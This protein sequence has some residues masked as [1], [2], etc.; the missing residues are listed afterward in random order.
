MSGAAVKYYLEVEPDVRIAVTLDD[1]TDPWTTPETVLMLHGN[2]ESAAAWFAWVPLFARRYRI[3]RP[4]MRGFGNSTPMREDYRW[5][6]ARLV[7]D[8]VAVC[9]RQ[10]AACVHVVAAKIS[11]QIALKFAIDHPDM[12]RSLTLVG[13]PP[14]VRELATRVPSLDLVRQHGVEAWARANMAERLGASM[15]PE[16]VEWWTRFMG[17][18]P[19]STQLGFMQHL[20]IFDIEAELGSVTQPTLVLAP[21][22]SLDEVAAWQHNI[23]ASRLVGV[24]GNSYHV[25]ASHAEFCAAQ[26]IRFIEEVS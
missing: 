12:V 8:L 3:I 21:E 26:T 10:E 25:A 6:L 16:A 7:A 9:R 18:T 4:D 17:R 2:S 15:P 13:P 20:A 11:C 24:P 19:V 5:S 1:F 14:P 23:P 22:Q